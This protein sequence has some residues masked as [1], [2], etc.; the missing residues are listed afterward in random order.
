MDNKLGDFI[1]EYREKNNLSLREFG[2]ISNIS[3]THIDSIEKGKDPRTGKRVKI[4][5]EIIEKLSKAMNVSPSYLFNLSI[6]KDKEISPFPETLAAHFDG[7]EFSKED[8]EDIEN[9]IEFVKQ[10]KKGKG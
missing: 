7:D 10:R 2:K 1:K 9:F 5:N 6:N 4:T 8:L 3:H